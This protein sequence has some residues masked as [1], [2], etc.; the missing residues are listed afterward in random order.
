MKNMNSLL[1]QAQ[2]M[3]AEMGRIQ[4]E[5]AETDFTGQAAGGMITVTMNGAMDLSAVKI[6]PELLADPD[7]EELED[8]ILAAFRAAQA[9]AKKASDERL[10][11]LTGGMNL[12]GM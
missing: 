6:N 4:Q 1:K 5:L 8:M 3:Q 7:A 2:K 10:G 12:P 9:E 11:P